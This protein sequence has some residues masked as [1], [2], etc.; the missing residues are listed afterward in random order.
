M[1]DITFEIVIQKSSNLLLLFHLYPPFVDFNF[2]LSHLIS[3]DF[4]RNVLID[5]IPYC[6][7]YS[8]EMICDLFVKN[9]C[10]FLKMKTFVWSNV[11]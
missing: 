3:R 7:C 10:A 11:I 9:F 2:Q 8:A 1:I 5:P 4:V 6:I